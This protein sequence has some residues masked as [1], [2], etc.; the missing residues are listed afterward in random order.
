MS[1]REKEGGGER[2]RDRVRELEEIFFFGWVESKTAHPLE[3]TT[4]FASF[5]FRRKS[6]RLGR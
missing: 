4:S 2:E 3:A 1:K 6:K 5:L